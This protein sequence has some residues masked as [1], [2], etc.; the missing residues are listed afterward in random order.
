MRLFR[1]SAQAHICD[2]E[3]SASALSRLS[4]SGDGGSAE[5]FAPTC[6]LAD[7]YG[8]AEGSSDAVAALLSQSP[9]GAARSL[10]PV[11]CFDRVNGVLWAAGIVSIAGEAEP[12]LALAR[13]EPTAPGADADENGGGAA[14]TDSAASAGAVRGRAILG[15]P[16]FSVPVGP[17]TTL[18]PV[19]AAVALLAMLDA[20]ADKASVAAEEEAGGDDTVAAAKAKR[21]AAVAAAPANVSSK[22]PVG[23]GGRGG[24]DRVPMEEMHRFGQSGR[25][26]QMGWG[27]G[28]MD[29]L[30][31]KVR[32]GGVGRCELWCCTRD[33]LPPPSSPPITRLHCRSARTCCSTASAS[34]ARATSTRVTSS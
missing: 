17:A 22:G 18:P 31:F 3:G 27:M 12:T 7:I 9:V 25:S 6:A 2:R 16:R 8:G 11:A 19:K 14:A 28:G 1:L 34:S 21:A 33:P 5:H 20:F 26:Y 29:C 32:W 4:L 30:G 13:F 23:G 24:A 10:H 15:D